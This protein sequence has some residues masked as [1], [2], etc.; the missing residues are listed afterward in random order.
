MTVMMVQRD[1]SLEWAARPELEREM[2]CFFFKL[3]WA[4]WGGRGPELELVSE[5]QV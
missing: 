5:G 4:D 3:V 1:C 2:F